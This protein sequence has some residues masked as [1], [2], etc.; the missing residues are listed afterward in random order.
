MAVVKRYGLRAARKEFTNYK[1]YQ[2]A[3]ILNIK[4][5]NL[6]NFEKNRSY[7]NEELVEKICELYGIHRGQLSVLTKEEIS[8]KK[9]KEKINGIISRTA[10]RNFEKG[11]VV[12][13]RKDDKRAVAVRYPE[14]KKV[15]V[16][17][18]SGDFDLILA[19]KMALEK[20]YEA[21]KREKE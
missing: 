11:C 14:C 19:A 2:V 9:E 5:N 6:M 8:L 15:V 20:F 16:S 1:M 7:P 18:R 13:Y 12:I 3:E 10:G 4:K 21:E 17:K